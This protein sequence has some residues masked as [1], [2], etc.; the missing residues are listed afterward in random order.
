V[1]K[2][3]APL[4]L[5][6]VFAFEGHAQ[7]ISPALYKASTI[8][9]SLKND[10]NS[11][12]R[13]SDDIVSVRGPGRVNIKHHDIVTILN[14]KA[15][16]AAV[17]VLYYNKKYNNYSNVQVR[18]YDKDGT[19]IKK[20]GKGDM[21]DGAGVSDENLLT[22]ER[23]LG[24]KHSV[25]SYPCTFECSYEED[26]TSTIDLNSWYMQHE[27]QSVQNEIY[28][29][30][31]DKSV[32]L[33]FTNKNIYINP[34]KSS[35]GNV[36]TYLW[37]ASNLPAFKIEEGAEAWRVLP[38]IDFAMNS[39]E[40]YGIPG[41]FSSWSAF[42]KWQG[43]LNKDVNSLSPQREQEIRKMT[44]TI[45]TDKAK[46]KFLYKYMQQNMRYVSIQLGIGGLK[47]FPATFVDQ[48]KYGDCKALSNYM[49]ALLK[50]VN[51]PSNYAI[52]NAEPNAEPAD[53]AF[54]F[55]SFNHVILCVPLNGD[56][57][58]LECTNSTMPFGK[59][60]S[61]TE[62]RRALLVTEEGGKLVNT[63][64]STMENNQ[65]SGEVHIILAADGGAKAKINL[66]GT[67]TYREDYV[68]VQSAKT[69]KQ[70]E[71]FTR[72]LNIKQ[73]IAFNFKSTPD[74]PDSKEVEIALDYDTFCDVKA[75]NKL[76]Y[77]PAA[78]DI[79]VFKLPVE[80]KRKTDYYFET[81]MQKSCNT[82]IDLPE[83]FEVES[84]PANQTLKFAYGS[85]DV[86]YTYDAAKN[87]VKA[88]TKF[89]IINHVI[90]A[91]QYN[92]LQQ[93]LDN[94]ARAQNKKLVIKR[95]A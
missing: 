3:F 71:Y 24:L 22:D 9:D 51:I 68:G 29:I 89:N 15:D 33:R 76:F 57:T 70:K 94:V 67:G 11:V 4:L 77:R 21:Y 62:N 46:V 93:F 28:S 26:L 45:K 80:E 92:D 19:V 27:E 66:S 52:I 49:G 58:W 36:D 25:A 42:G 41:D 6:S 30:I 90:P 64:R 54:P 72:W 20:Y 23:F 44:D 63:P 39:F 7:T 82:V 65:F 12:V 8:P 61:F 79:C 59:L 87:K 69:E 75:G 18:V 56:T 88:S 13:Y 95:K 32:G 35:N 60:G 37:K 31:V 91:A 48:K 14:E 1:K 86:S 50:A 55:D 84:L 5:L 81:P 85:Y 38:R 10:A 73:P 53:P 34:V 78:L 2:F 43:E 16:K 40:F 17:L 83:G 74:G 47:P